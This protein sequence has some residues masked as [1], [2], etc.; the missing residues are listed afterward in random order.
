MNVIHM[1][2]RRGEATAAAKLKADA[3][4]AVAAQEQASRV[5]SIGRLALFDRYKAPGTTVID[6]GGITR[7]CDDLG[8]PL[9]SV[10]DVG[11]GIL[12][13]CVS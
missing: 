11:T 3:D 6:F 4:A 7:L 2:R 12:C 1:F 13:A 8:Y 5:A 10:S 9:D